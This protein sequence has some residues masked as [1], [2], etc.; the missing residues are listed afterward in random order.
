M[1]RVDIPF[2]SKYTAFFFDFDY[3][4]ADSSTGIVTCFRIVLDRYSFSGIDDDA[5][6]KTIGMTLEDSFERLT[7]VENKEQLNR[8]KN[9]YLAEADEIMSDNTQLYPDTIPLIKYLKDQG[10]SMGIISTKQSYIIRQTLVKYGIESLFDTVIG[11]LDVEEMKPSPEGL[12]LG[13]SRLHTNKNHTL[14]L[15]DNLIDAQT[16][17]AAGV[18]FVGVT[19]GTTSVEE[20]S[21][22][23]HQA[24]ISRLAELRDF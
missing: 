11:M 20:F 5:I 1:S 8:F 4:L 9:E 23:P 17:Q 10:A 18:D 19:T 12:L 22:Y 6:K 2:L 13:M 24:V 16:A 14:Y 7:G 15:G 3:T 21:A